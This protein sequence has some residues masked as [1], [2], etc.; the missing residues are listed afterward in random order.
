MAW[1]HMLFTPGVQLSVIQVQEEAD[2]CSN[3]QSVPVDDL[4]SAGGGRASPALYIYIYMN[5]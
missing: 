2:V 3:Q 1:F 4:A 5:E